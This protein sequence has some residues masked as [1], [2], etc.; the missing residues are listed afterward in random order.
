MI[1]FILIIGVA[2][3]IFIG[4]QINVE[5]EENFEFNF[6][7]KLHP[8]SIQNK[9]LIS[10]EELDDLLILLNECLDQYIVIYRSL[11]VKDN[12]WPYFI[13]LSR[14]TREQI[15]LVNCSLELSFSNDYF[16][17]EFIE[18]IRKYT[19]ALF[20]A[21]EKNEDMLVKIA[22]LNQGR[23][24]NYTKS[25]FKKDS[26]HIATVDKKLGNLGETFQNKYLGFK[27]RYSL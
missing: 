1:I 24:N 23:L 25:D 21:V 15:S 22:L 17:K 16:L 13:E 5:A 18:I 26:K 20:Y 8:Y 6:S 10:P 2:V 3:V 14:R 7:R 9:E 12:E 27:E 11:L 4:K 19:I